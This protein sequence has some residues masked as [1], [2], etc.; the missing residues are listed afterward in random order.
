MKRILITF[1][2]CIGCASVSVNLYKGST[3]FPTTDSSKVSVFQQKP[4]KENFIEI[5][6]ITVSE[7]YRWSDAER[8]LKKAASK[9]GGD[10]VYIIH[11][12]KRSEAA[13]FPV[14]GSGIMGAMDSE[15]IV[16]GVVIKYMD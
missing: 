11:Q 6:E 3:V 15:I 10:A 12:G 2:A 5:G 14:Y 16:T 8:E 1:I 7:V 9:L 4:Q 13:L